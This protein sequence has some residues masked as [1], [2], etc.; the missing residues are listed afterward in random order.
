MINWTGG[1]HQSRIGGDKVIDDA[2]NE[3]TTEATEVMGN[4]KISHQVVL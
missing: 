1:V 2:V 4:G 3:F